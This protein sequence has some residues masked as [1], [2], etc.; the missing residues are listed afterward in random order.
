MRTWTILLTAAIGGCMHPP[1][2]A[3]PGPRQGVEVEAEFDVAWGAVI[4]YFA[5]YNVP[6]AT[7]DKSSGFI[8]A[9]PVGLG[10]ITKPGAWADCGAWGSMRKKPSSVI[11]NVTVRERSGGST[12]RVT[13]TWEDSCV[14]FGT[15]ESLVESALK[16]R[17]EAG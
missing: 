9:A 13:A 16:E 15:W 6:I 17:A 10:H 7:I 14:T 12:I 8:A 2:T 3:P 5:E 1:R 11:Y 4:D